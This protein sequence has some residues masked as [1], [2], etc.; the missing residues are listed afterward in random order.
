VTTQTKYATK[1]GVAW[2]ARPAFRLTV[3]T[4]GTSKSEAVARAL[5]SRVPL[6][7]PRENT[8]PVWLETQVGY[9]P[10]T[11]RMSGVAPPPPGDGVEISYASAA[12]LGQAIIVLVCPPGGLALAAEGTIATLG[13]VEPLEEIVERYPL[14]TR[15][16]KGRA[17]ILDRDGRMLP[18]WI[19]AA[20]PERTKDLATYAWSDMQT[21]GKL[22]AL[23]TYAA[24]LLAGQ[25]GGALLKYADLGPLAEHVVGEFVESI[26]D[27]Q[28]RRASGSGGSSCVSLSSFGISV[29]TSCSELSLAPSLPVSPSPVV[30][31]PVVIP[32]AIQG[33]PVPVAV[34][35]ALTQVFATGAQTV[36]ISTPESNTIQ[37]EPERYSYRSTGDSNS[38]TASSSSTSAGSDSQGGGG[39]AN[40]GRE[41]SHNMKGLPTGITLTGP[42]G[43]FTL[44]RR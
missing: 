36:R 37:I 39:D 15:S 16:E 34:A 29:G 13:L 17:Y 19:N 12:F 38:A 20:L 21:H 14:G 35:Q 23:G 42:F 27:Q 22:G 24:S 30:Q 31:A 33:V 18:T 3:D 9:Q 11:F 7:R 44:E 4:I 6:E 10:A 2:D 40:S 41:R 26:A 43:G 25:A 1:D 28:I 5:L 8:E 32:S